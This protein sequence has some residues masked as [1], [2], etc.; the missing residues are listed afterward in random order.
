MPT[1]L[2]TGATGFV[3]SNLVA[4]LRRRDWRVRCLVRNA[5]RGQSLE[6]LGAV[7]HM[8]SLDD[9]ET[10]A[11]AATDVDY[12]FHVAGRVR[13]LSQGEFTADNVDGT[14]NVVEAAALQP[15]PPVVV[16]VSSL[17]A[18]GPSKPGKPR[19]EI[20]P[21][22]P[23]S[24]YGRSKLSAERAAA[25]LADEVPISIIRPPIIFGPA[26]KASLAIFRG[27]KWMRL[28]PVPGFRTF[29][30]SLVHVADLCDAMIRIAERGSRVASKPDDSP[31]SQGVYYVAAERTV[32]YGHLGKLAAEAIGCKGVALPLPRSLF[33]LVGGMA[34][35]YGQL[36]GKLQVLNLDKAREAAAPGWECD[37]QRLRNELDYR[38][39]LPLQQ[40]FGET[41]DWYRQQGWL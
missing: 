23:I 5:A 40:R 19:R 27:V 7:L 9:V 38:P 2:V 35:L 1:A 25:Q 39:A 13:A 33:W 3:G 14:R 22:Q 18:G 10:L 31:D 12:V 11:Q 21:D 30:V 41:A 24:D 34:Q 4:E 28:H 26:D 36:T 17:A 8:G 20:D 37:D 29:P 32:P 16:F 15:K 6:A